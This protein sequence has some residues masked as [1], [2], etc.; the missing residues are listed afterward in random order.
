M[1]AL[2]TA[3]FLLVS[4]TTYAQNN[5]NVKLQHVIDTFI[6]N[7]KIP[8]I[9]VAVVQLDTVMYAVSG[10]NST[11]N[12]TPISTSAKFHLGSNS[13]AFTSFMAAKLVEEGKLTWET[14]LVDVM[15]ELKATIHPKFQ[16]ITLAQL[17]SH[18]AGIKAYTGAAEFAKLPDFKGTIQE[19]RFLLAQYALT[20]DTLLTVGNYTYSNLGYVIVASMLEHITHK[21]W[22]EQ[23]KE[24]F[25]TNGLGSFFIGFPNKEATTNPW[26]HSMSKD[27]LQTQS[28]SFDYDLSIVAP[29]GDMSMNI[30]DY[31]KF[32]QLH[33]KGISGN[34]NYLKADT[35]QKV[36]FGKEKYAF[37]WGNG[38][39]PTAGLVST[40]N[41]SAGNFYAHTMIFKEK[42]IAII[43][44]A[45]ASSP[46]IDKSVVQLRRYLFD[47]YTVVK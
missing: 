4:A 30:M 7:N 12:G 16:H 9:A 35:Y 27:T 45:N 46:S 21:T 6:V 24:T 28:P 10:V 14:Q 32:V 3:L 41:G 40:H 44:I 18:T 15:P 11:V 2:I 13:K 47:L 8:A 37:G 31:S 33:L 23:L 34:D 39:N 20:N 38:K 22:E 29:A 25:K 42:K 17:L 5:A 43:V 1:K 26:G 36:H 19:Q